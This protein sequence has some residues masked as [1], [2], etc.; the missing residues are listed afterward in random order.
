MVKVFKM[1]NEYSKRRVLTGQKKPFLSYNRKEA[2]QLQD[3]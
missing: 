2:I 1:S 3:V